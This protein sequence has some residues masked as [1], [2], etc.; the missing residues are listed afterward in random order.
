M[1]KAEGYSGAFACWV[2]AGVFAVG[3]L[4]L[5]VKLKEVQIEDSADYKYASARQSM[6]RVQIGGERGR[7]VDRNG[8]V[9]A[10]N[11]ESVSIV[12]NASAFRA[13]TWEETV[14]RIALAITNLSERIGKAVVLPERAIRRHV[15]QSLAMP[16]H[17]WND[18]DHETLAKFFENEQNFPGFGVSK[19]F[20][21]VY[22]QGS[23]ASHLIGYVGRDYGEDEA[24]DEKFNFRIPELRGRSGIEVYYDSFLRGVPGEKRLIVDARGFSVDEWTVTEGSRGLDL[25]LSID[26]KI[27]QEAERQLSGVC[28]A[29]VVIDPRNGEVLAMA[30]S[31]SYDPNI[32]V[33]RLRPEL[34]RKY[35]TDPAKPLLNRAVGGTYA[36]GSTF[37]PVTALAGLAMGFPAREQYYCEGVFRLG[38]MNLRCASRWGHG[39]VDMRKAIMESCNPY[40]CNLGVDVGTNAIIHVARTLGL[41]E[42]TGVDFGIDLKGSIPDAQWKMKTYGEQWFPGDVAQMSIGQGMLLVT[43][44]QMALVA[45]AIGTGKL[46]VPRIKRD[47]PVVCRDLP[48]PKKH[49]SVVREGMYMVVNGK[50]SERGTGWRGG[51]GL[52][53]KVCGKTGTAEIGRG[54]RRRKNAWFI[55]YAPAED[56]VVAV[57]IVVENGD[58]GGATAAPKVCRVLKAV[59]DD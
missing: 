52:E 58:S 8:I 23:L 41:G 34:Y 29:C 26:V 2:V 33:P 20:E 16:L 31:P 24:G 40:F 18:V 4:I 43:P 44:M 28:G 55:A 13:R 48:F 1:N 19:G 51:E 46:V 47:L 6:R 59:F 14:S 5:A 54:E 17:V 56:P 50:D 42:K 57:A 11:R 35:S 49:L 3:L 21:R 7:I 15:N 22:P 39:M 9:L 30:S 25:E 12:C 10:D 45:G 38:G 37:K 36:P 27:Q 32:F 53:V